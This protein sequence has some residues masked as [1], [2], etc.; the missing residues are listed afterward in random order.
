MSVII[1]LLVRL[2]ST[3]F[4][5]GLN[6]DR[7]ASKSPVLVDPDEAVEPDDDEDPEEEVDAPGSEVSMEK[8]ELIFEFDDF[9][10]AVGEHT[11]D[12]RIVRAQLDAAHVGAANLFCNG[13]GRYL[14]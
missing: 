4:P 14:F 2:S 1:R 11:A 13:P 12:E 7:T 6:T 8:V 9:V 5:L 10:F 3:S